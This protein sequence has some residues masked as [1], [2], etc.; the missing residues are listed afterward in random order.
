MLRRTLLLALVGVR[1][2]KLRVASRRA[3]AFGAV[4]APAAVTISPAVAAELREATFSGGD[5]RF[6]QPFFDEIKYKGVQRVSVGS[7][8]DGTRA[9]NVAYN[10]AKCS[11]KFLLGTFLRNVDPT[12]ETDPWSASGSEPS[13][14]RSVIWVQSE[15]ERELALKAM[16][17]LQESGIYGKDKPFLTEVLD[18]RPFVPEPENQDFYINSEKSY[19]KL[20]KK[21]GRAAFF[22][23]T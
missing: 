22:E 8:D 1:A 10:P 6:L 13:S 16:R 11:Y 18:A 2:L 3:F 20:L 7:M 14:Y 4:A 12:R 5:P 17:L 15:E 9:I 23:K 21:T 19:E